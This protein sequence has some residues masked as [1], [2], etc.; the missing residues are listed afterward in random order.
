MLCEGEGRL[1]QEGGVKDPHRSSMN[2]RMAAENNAGK[3]Q[4]PSSLFLIQAQ[5]Y[6]PAPRPPPA[7][8]ACVA[9][10]QFLEAG[11]GEAQNKG[12]GGGGGGNDP[13]CRNRWA[14]SAPGRRKEAALVFWARRAEG[15]LSVSTPA[16]PRPV[17]HRSSWQSP[18]DPPPGLAESSELLQGRGAFCGGLLSQRRG[19]QSSPPW[20]IHRCG[21]AAGGRQARAGL[22]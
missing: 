4:L 9:L 10:I 11:E 19:L 20:L 21:G 3:E 1:R 18:H 7:Q 22:L 5:E 12:G 2:L 14:A 15:G 16:L 17:L 13:E 8:P 6:I